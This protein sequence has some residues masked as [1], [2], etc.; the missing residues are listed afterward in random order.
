MT[1]VGRHNG[2]RQ[3]WSEQTMTVVF[4]G[5]RVAFKTIKLAQDL[6]GQRQVVDI[7][8]GGA[9]GARAYGHICPEGA[10]PADG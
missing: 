2:T 8:A 7:T 9:Q 1:A 6:V 5:Q 3:E 4:W 10:A